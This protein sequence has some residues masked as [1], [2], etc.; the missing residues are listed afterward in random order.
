MLMKIIVLFIACLT[1]NT[2]SEEY[3]NSNSMENIMEQ[4]ELHKKM[5]IEIFNSIWPKMDKSDRTLEED[6]ALVDAAHASL[7]H[8]RISGNKLNIQRGYWM[9]S[10]VYSVVKRYDESNFYAKLCYDITMEEK[11]DDFDYSYACEAMAR[12]YAGIGDVDKAKKFYI[13]AE[14]SVDNIKGKEDREL[15]I[16]DLKSGDWSGVEF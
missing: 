8:W 12:S 11:F 16:S 14:K 3:N 2:I 10:R 13:L 6:N 4:K 7:Y 1:Y 15:F 9:I 5:A